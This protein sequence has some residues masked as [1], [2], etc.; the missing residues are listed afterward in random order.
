MH[1]FLVIY[2]TDVLPEIVTA[3]AYA[4]EPVLTTFRCNDPDNFFTTLQVLSIRSVDVHR[5]QL[6]EPHEVAETAR[7]LRARARQDG[8]T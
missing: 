7:L 1:T 8:K 5:I 6:L 4:V 3:D 2:K